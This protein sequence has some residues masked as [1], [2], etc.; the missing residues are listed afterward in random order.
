MKIIGIV[1]SQTRDSTKDLDKVIDAFWKVYEEGDIICSG[2]CPTGGDRFAYLLHK[3]HQ[4]P[5]LEFPAQWRK[6]G[7]KAGHMRNT[8]I[9]RVSRVLIACWNKKSPGTKGTIDKFKE[10][11]PKGKV[12]IV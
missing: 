3:S 8:D 4:L 12:I 5:Y 10:F 1:G 2:G 6:H 9:A 11:H 7:K